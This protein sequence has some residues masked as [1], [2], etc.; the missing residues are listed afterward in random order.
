MNNEFSRNTV[1]IIQSK[2]EIFQTNKIK[3]E[4]EKIH[5][6][7]KKLMGLWIKNDVKGRSFEQIV[8]LILDAMQVCIY[9]FVGIG[10]VK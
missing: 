3:Y 10:A 9:I 4:L 2:F 6:F 5:T 7:Y 1:K 8:V